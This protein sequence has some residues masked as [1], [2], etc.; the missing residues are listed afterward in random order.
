MKNAVF[1]RS[2]GHSDLRE[3]VE[4]WS[5]FNVAL[6]PCQGPVLKLNLG[7]FWEPAP[8][9]VTHSLP[10]SF[11]LS[12]RFL[13]K[14]RGSEPRLKPFVCASDVLLL[15]VRCRC[16]VLLS[17]LRVRSARL[18]LKR[19]RFL[20][21]LVLYLTMCLIVYLPPPLITHLL[22]TTA[23]LTESVVMSV[24]LKN[25]FPPFC[26]DLATVVV[27]KSVPVLAFLAEVIG[28]DKGRPTYTWTDQDI[29]K[30]RMRTPLRLRL[31]GSHAMLS[32][33]L[34]FGRHMRESCEGFW[35]AVG[36]CT[37]NS[38]QLGVW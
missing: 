1:S 27:V 8:T 16:V 19:A 12:T 9:R 13:A 38:T 2:F 26:A 14:K 33:S 36:S 28:P 25:V 31:S 20:I 10:P 5:G 11:L 3:G 4:A 15:D 22:N 24:C 29:H 6:R 21:S 37:L 35:Y 30:V 18:H 17:S 23:F 7:E 34:S 32:F